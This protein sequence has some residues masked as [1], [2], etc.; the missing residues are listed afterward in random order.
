MYVYMLTG[1]YDECDLEIDNCEQECIDT[2]SSFVCSCYDGYTL[3]RNGV[4]C[5]PYCSET[6]TS[7]SGS[8]QT[9]SWPDYYP[10]DFD[11]NWI[12][13]LS[14]TSVTADSPIAF[15]VDTTAY[16]MSS[17]CDNEYIEF[18]DGIFANSSSLGKFCGSNP[19]PGILTS[20][21]QAKVVFHAHDSHPD[22][23]PGVRVTYNIDGMSHS[24][25]TCRSLIVFNLVQLMSATRITEGV[26]TGVLTLLSR[27]SV[28]AEKA[29]P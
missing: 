23:L 13:D 29:I 1:T 26:S 15:T 28:P 4:L 22:G 10:E 16:G 8:F 3:R 2:A 5:I 17:D 21:F 19:P 20:G 7:P 9:P 11:C 6:F 24:T 12:I 27:L 25:V 18:F 14:N